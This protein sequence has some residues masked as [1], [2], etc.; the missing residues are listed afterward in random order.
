MFLLRLVG[1]V[2][3][4]RSMGTYWYSGGE[5]GTER[6]L[7]AWPVVSTTSQDLCLVRVHVGGTI[8]IIGCKVRCTRNRT[9]G[10]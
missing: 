6:R 10:M 8:C 9:T 5:G 3:G 1:R 7:A 4:G 2:A